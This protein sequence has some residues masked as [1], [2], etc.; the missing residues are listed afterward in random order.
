[1]CGLTIHCSDGVPA[2]QRCTRGACVAAGQWHSSRKQLS[3]MIN[4]NMRSTNYARNQHQHWY[5]Y[6]LES[7]SASA[8]PAGPEQHF[9]YSHCLTCAANSTHMTFCV[10]TA[11]KKE[12]LMITHEKQVTVESLYCAYWHQ[13]ISMWACSACT[14]QQSAPTMHVSRSSQ[15]L[16]HSMQAMK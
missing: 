2:M 15:L 9:M 10:K 13:L 5:A 6:R 7:S 8:S 14:N 11:V 1:M 4:L 3:A 16:L 12:R